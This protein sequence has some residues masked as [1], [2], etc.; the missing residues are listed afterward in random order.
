MI[1]MGSAGE[2]ENTASDR[3]VC[4][5]LQGLLV[6]IARLLPFLTYSGTQTFGQ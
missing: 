1:G 6:M 3:L 2:Q 4:I 5:P